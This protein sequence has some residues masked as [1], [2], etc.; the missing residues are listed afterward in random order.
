MTA[1]C[2]HPRFTTTTNDSAL[3]AALDNFG[4]ARLLSYQI[5]QHVKD[6]RLVTVLDDYAPP[7]V[8]VHLVHR[9]GRHVTQKVRAF[10]D[11]AVTTLRA[12]ASL[13]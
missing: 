7:P 12:D 9:E 2:A 11:L 3:T 13:N 4:I 5:A 1:P 8:P 10:F 6:G